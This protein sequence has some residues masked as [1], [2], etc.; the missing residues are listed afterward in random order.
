MM[1]EKRKRTGLTEKNIL[2]KEKYRNIMAWL[3]LSIIKTPIREAH[4]VNVLVENKQIKSSLPIKPL[5]REYKLSE[6]LKEKWIPLRI[7]FGELVPEN[8]FKSK[9]GLRRALERL[10]KLGLIISYKP[11]KSK[12]G[13]SCLKLTDKGADMYI[14]WLIKNRVDMLNGADVADLLRIINVKVL[15]E[16]KK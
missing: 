2:E 3:F 13:Y 7:R 10:K 4:L 12:R 9:Y 6:F 11:K 8:K 14:R 5:G 1:V 15:N 16:L